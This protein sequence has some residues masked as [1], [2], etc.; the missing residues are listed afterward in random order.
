MAHH[1]IC[2]AL[3]VL[4]SNVELVRIELRHDANASTH[5]VVQDHLVELEAAVERL[6]SLAARLRAWHETTPSS[7]PDRSARG[8]M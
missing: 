6:K 3:T 8:N 5:F 2:T 1:E 4:Q 7:R